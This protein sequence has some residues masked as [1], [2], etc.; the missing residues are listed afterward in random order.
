MAYAPNGARLPRNP[1]LESLHELY[2]LQKEKC[3]GDIFFVDGFLGNDTYDGLSRSSPL[4]TITHALTHCVAGYDDHIIVM[5]G[6]DQ[7]PA[8]PINVNKDR[9]HILG[10]KTPPDGSWLTLQP[11]VDAAAFSLANGIEACE[12]AG[13][14]L[15]GGGPNSTHGAIELI[16]SGT[17]MNWIHH[18]CFGHYW[19]DGSQDGIRLAGNSWS[20]IIEDN[21]FYGHYVLNG[22]LL[23]H[24]IYLYGGGQG[25]NTIRRNYLL[26]CN[27][28]ILLTS[29]QPICDFIIDENII[30]CGT[31]AQG[32]AIDLG[33]T[34][35][36]NMISRN[37]ANFGDTEMAQNPFRDQAGAGANHWMD[38]MRG[39]TQ[40]MPA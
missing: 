13:F 35:T 3:I 38:N 11:N 36:G 40:I 30:A 21:W 28:A 23:R 25:A 39:I 18:N 5:D 27:T 20:N 12:I 10:V 9:V 14:M 37:R 7:E 16:N 22:K 6:Y 17:N 4:K 19:I 24:G 15:A 32:S 31:D 33:P 26:G 2:R 34:S 8:W 29:P 1:S